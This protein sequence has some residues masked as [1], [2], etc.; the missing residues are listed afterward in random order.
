MWTIPTKGGIRLMVH[1][2]CLIVNISSV[3]ATTKTVAVKVATSIHRTLLPCLPSCLVLCPLLALLLKRI[4][5][6]LICFEKFTFLR[7]L[8]VKKTSFC[9]QLNQVYLWLVA[10]PKGVSTCCSHENRNR[11]EE[12]P[13]P[14]LEVD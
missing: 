9:L 8:C 7:Y 3:S 2:A 4:F 14:G 1:V 6:Q 5:S 11:L 10:C 12:V 13:L